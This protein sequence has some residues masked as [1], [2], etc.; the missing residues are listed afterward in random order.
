MLKK[1]LP[2]GQVLRGSCLFSTGELAR[3]NV[4]AQGL[5]ECTMREDEVLRSMGLRPCVR[6][7]DPRVKYF[8]VPSLPFCSGIAGSPGALPRTVPRGIGTHL[9][10]LLGAWLAV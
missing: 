10:Y 5:A 4:F 8:D 9:I 6:E 1:E 7:G 3:R 2:T